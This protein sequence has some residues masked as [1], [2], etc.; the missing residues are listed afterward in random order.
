MRA[1]PFIHMQRPYDIISSSTYKQMNICKFNMRASELDLVPNT[2]AYA[3]TSNH[4]QPLATINHNMFQIHVY[5]H[6][7]L[8]KDQEIGPRRYT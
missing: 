4:L 3:F 2:Y 7:F 8:P 6:W 5:I 1:Q